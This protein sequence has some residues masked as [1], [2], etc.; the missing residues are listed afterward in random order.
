MGGIFE[1]SSFDLNSLFG[2]PSFPEPPRELPLRILGLITGAS[3]ATI[4]QAFRAKVIGAHPD[5]RP[6]FD[7]PELRSMAQEGR[8]DLPDMQELVWA[9]DCALR[10]APAP[11]T[12]ID[13]CTEGVQ[14]T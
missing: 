12:D 7:N 11:V 13:G 1:E 10:Q 2:L 5:L 3:Q 9:R 4:R 14:K 8:G 6:A